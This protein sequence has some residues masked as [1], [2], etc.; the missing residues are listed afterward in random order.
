MVGMSLFTDRPRLRWAAPAAGLTLAL[1]GTALV[2]TQAGAQTEL[3]PKTAQQLLVEVRQAGQDLA[4]GKPSAAGMSGTVVQ[5]SE[6]GLPDLAGLLGGGGSSS[7]LA[8]TVTGTHTWRVWYAGP[9]RVRLALVGDASESDVIRNGDQ[10]WVWSS[11]SKTAT[12]YALDDERT[13]DADPS[14]LP[15]PLPSGSPTA[16]AVTP[17]QWADQ[18]LDAV[19]PST[20]VGAPRQVTVAGR[21]AYE[22]TLVP[23]TPGTLVAAVKIALDGE[24]KVP[25]RLQVLSTEVSEPAIDVAFTS[26][27][28]NVPEARQFEFTPP[29]GTTVKDGDLPGVDGDKADPAPSAKASPA[30]SGGS[31]VDP[32]GTRPGP[33]MV[34]ADWST[35]LVGVMPTEETPG[36]PSASPNS[37]QGPVPA[38]LSAL[39]RSLPAESG[40]WGSGRVLRGTLFTLVIADDG[41]FAVGAVEPQVAF[42]ALADAP[43]AR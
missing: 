8:S 4:D 25:L 35:V 2:S 6:P 7:D 40:P 34:G 33:R 31:A 11:E 24:H 15:V 42:D 1:A 3:A 36:S 23:R 32:T 21:S 27:D 19:G 12:K 43:A 41:R 14:A 10:V 5:T 18:V 28:F 38:E 17:S 37:E 22:L 29:P 13:G 16:L 30:P 26:V 20:E 39:L 9:E